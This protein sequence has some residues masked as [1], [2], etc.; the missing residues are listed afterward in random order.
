MT[1]SVDRDGIGMT[2]EQVNKLFQPFTQA[3]SSTTRKFGG[4]GL[5]LALT[6]RFCEMLGGSVSVSSEPGVGSMFT[7]ELPLTVP[8]HVPTQTATPTAAQAAG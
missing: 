4:T 2:S 3:D 5:G 6:L 7:V 1:N 8:G